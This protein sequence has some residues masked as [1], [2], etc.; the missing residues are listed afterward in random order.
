MSGGRDARLD[1]A[2][3]CLGLVIDPEDRPAVLEHLAA[4]EEAVDL[5]MSF[6]LP[7]DLPA[8]ALFRP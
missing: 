1:A 8:A 6:P 7:D 4:L 5:V 2:A 3:A